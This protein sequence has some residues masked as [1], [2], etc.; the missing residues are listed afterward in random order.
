LGK[1]DGKKR[2]GG[3]WEKGGGPKDPLKEAGT[4]PD[5]KK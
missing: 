5:F 4:L 1:V 2:V 3:W